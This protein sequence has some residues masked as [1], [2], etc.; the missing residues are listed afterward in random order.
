MSNKKSFFQYNEEKGT[1]NKPDDNYIS[2]IYPFEMYEITVKL[3]PDGKF[4]G[5]EEVQI[6]KDF[7]SFNQIRQKEIFTYV[8]EMPLE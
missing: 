3:S 1:G 6:N 8:E 7:R 5:I 4:M 2:I